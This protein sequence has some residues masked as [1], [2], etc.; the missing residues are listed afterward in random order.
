VLVRLIRTSNG[1][2]VVDTGAR[3]GRGAYLC[4]DPGCLERGLSRGRLGHAFR[5][6]S[7]AAPNL[8]AAV[9]AAAGREAPVEGALAR[10]VETDVIAVKA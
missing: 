6:P 7:E 3:I 2:V 4:P 1:T 9:W 5:K 8:A 10:E